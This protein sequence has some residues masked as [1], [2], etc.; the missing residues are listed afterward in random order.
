MK[1]GPRLAKE[2]QNIVTQYSDS[3]A[4]EVVDE[5]TPVWRISFTMPEGTVYVGERYTL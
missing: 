4:L 5:M 3:M 1:A 2:A